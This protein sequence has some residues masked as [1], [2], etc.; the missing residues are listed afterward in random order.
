M[1]FIYQTFS[2]M[3]VTFRDESNES[4]SIMIGYNDATVIAPN[5]PLTVRSKISLA[6]VTATVP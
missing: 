6:T 5:H 4:S 1:K 2:R 3:S